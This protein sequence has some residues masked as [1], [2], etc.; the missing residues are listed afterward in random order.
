MILGTIDTYCWLN[1]SVQPDVE[2]GRNDKIEA[3]DPYMSYNSGLPH[4]GN[5]PTTKRVYVIKQGEF[6][7]V[8]TIKYARIVL[9]C[10]CIMP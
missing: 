9:I 7:L 10:P 4:I 6:E 2:M 8:S 1:S 5:K 3:R